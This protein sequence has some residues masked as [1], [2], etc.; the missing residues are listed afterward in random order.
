MGTGLTLYDCL[1]WD[2]NFGVARWARIPKGRLLD[3]EEV[4]SLVPGLDS[5]KLRGGALWYDGLCSNTERLVVGFVRTAENH[6][7]VA[8]NRIGV[9]SWIISDGRLEGARFEDLES[10]GTGEIRCRHA[11]DCRGPLSGYPLSGETAEPLPGAARAFAHGINFVV[12]LEAAERIAFAVSGRPAG[13]QRLYFSVP[14]RQT[15]MIGTEWFLYQGNPE[16]A[17]LTEAQCQAF[18]DHFNI[19]FPPAELDLGDIRF[20]YHGLVPA[21]EGASSIQNIKLL[22]HFRILAER[23]TKIRGLVSLVGVKYTTAGHVAS[24]VLRELLPGW[25]EVDSADQEYIGR[26]PAREEMLQQLNDRWG[27]HAGAGELG[28]LYADYGS[29]AADILDL[30]DLY[31]GDDPLALWKAQ[32]LFGVREEMARSL[33]DLYFRRSNRGDMGR[34][35]RFELEQI[36]DIAGAELGWDAARKAAEINEMLACY[37][38]FIGVS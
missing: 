27:A 9:S 5:D 24:E 30:A 22:R 32:A 11:V 6:G 34:P 18:V 12:D 15:A 4:M 36:A 13:Q 31:G 38:D 26:C 23:E 19:V 2:R 28:F 3:A 33:A 37:P 7:A 29:E 16:D 20:V 8:A 14:W 17:V 21:D 1:S 35:S 10:G 25:R